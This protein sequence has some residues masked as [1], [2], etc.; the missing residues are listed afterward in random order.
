MMRLL[1]GILLLAFSL[2]LAAQQ[3][4]TVTFDTPSSGGAPSSYRLFRD[5]TDLG[6]VTSGQNVP[7]M[8]P[9]GTGPWTFHIESRNAACGASPLPACPR[10]SRVVTIGPPPLQPPGPVINVTITAPCATT[11][12]PTCTI[13]VVTP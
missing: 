12:P 9:A 7:T 10:F 13:N 4:G 8:F 11:S 2:P 5:T 6:A 3:A 1:A